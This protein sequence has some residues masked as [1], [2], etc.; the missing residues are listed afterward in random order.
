MSAT[1]SPIS[2]A[3]AGDDISPG[4]D[5]CSTSMKNRPGIALS[6]PAVKNSVPSPAGTTSITHTVA[7]AIRPGWVKWWR[8]SVGSTRR[9]ASASMT[10]MASPRNGLQ[11][12]A[13]PGTARPTNSEAATTSVPLRPTQASA[14]A[15]RAN[16]F[17]VGKLRPPGWA[18]GP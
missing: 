5:I 12:A 17:I 14:A 3:K 9:N 4:A 15:G 7:A 2:A 18:Y 8:S 13:S 6:R 16:T 1:S 10:T 11:A